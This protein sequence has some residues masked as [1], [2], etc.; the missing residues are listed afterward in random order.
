MDIG[1]AMEFAAPE[2]DPLR[3]FGL[4]KSMLLEVST[5]TSAGTVRC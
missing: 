5:E 4:P 1:E 3:R 2:D